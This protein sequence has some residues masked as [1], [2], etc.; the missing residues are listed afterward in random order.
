M[1]TDD[2]DWQRLFSEL[3]PALILFA[4]QF[5][6][7]H[8]RAEDAVQDGFARFWKNRRRVDDARAYLFACVRSAA[9]DGHRRRATRRHHEAEGTAPARDEAMFRCPVEADERRR[10][11]EAALRRL[12]DDQRQAIVMKL[13]GGLSFRQIADVAQIKPD[14]AASRYRYGLEKLRQMLSPELIA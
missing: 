1:A 13:W 5:V 6:P 12:P 4:R 11:V 8:D 9:L 7:S 3:G 10:A 14:T 2:H